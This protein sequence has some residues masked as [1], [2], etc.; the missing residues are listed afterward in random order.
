[1]TRFIDLY[2]AEYGDPPVSAFIVM[3]WDTVKVLAQAIEKAGTTDGA[4]V[5][6]AMG[7]D[8]R[9]L[10]DRARELH[11]FNP[12]LGFR[13]CRLGISYP[14]IYELQVQAI[15]EAA[16]RRNPTGRMTTPQDV[17]NTILAGNT[18]SWSCMPGM[19]PGE[20]AAQIGQ[21]RPGVSDGSHR[22]NRRQSA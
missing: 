17:A 16:T 20:I 14:E 9:K 1:M 11:E 21:P 2:T 6:K 8:A 13:G 7:T 12:M 5:A 18:G 10:E 19:S 22:K 15:I 3:G 4:A